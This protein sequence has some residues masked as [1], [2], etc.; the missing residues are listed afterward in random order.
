M[1]KGQYEIK[2]SAFSELYDMLIPKDDL[3]RQIS[4]RIDFSFVYDE[5]KDKYCP[6]NGRNA[7]NPVSISLEKLISTFLNWLR[8]SEKL[9]SP[10]SLVYFK[11][12]SKKI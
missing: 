5:L 2:F 8:L 7:V 10:L 1:L 12:L 4:D 11:A 9:T 3:L 6:D